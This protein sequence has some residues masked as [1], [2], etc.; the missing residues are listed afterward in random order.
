MAAHAAPLSDDLYGR[1]ALPGRDAPRRV[2]RGK[3]AP[4]R[5]LAHAKGPAAHTTLLA[6][7]PPPAA[8]A[9]PAAPPVDAL[10]RRTPPG[11]LSMAW[12]EDVILGAKP[13]LAAQQAPLHGASAPDDLGFDLPPSDQQLQRAQASAPTPAAGSPDRP[14]TAGEYN[15]VPE[16]A[17]GAGVGGGIRMYN[18]G[19]RVHTRSKAMM[20]RQGRTR[21]RQE[22]CPYTGRIVDYYEDK[23]P[24]A[25]YTRGNVSKEALAH[26]NP[27]LVAAQGYDH[28]RAKKKRR[29][30]LADAPQ[31][32]GH[33]VVP[34][35]VRNEGRV[36]G[37]MEERINR[38][39]RH[40]QNG[41]RPTWMRDTQRPT[42]YVGY[43]NMLRVLPFV[44]PT[45]REGQQNRFDYQHDVTPN[46]NVKAEIDLLRQHM[47][48]NKRRPQVEHAPGLQGHA[49]A[50]EGAQPDFGDRTDRTPTQR[51]HYER[52][53]LLPAG[54]LVGEGSGPVHGERAAPVRSKGLQQRDVAGFAN[55]GPSLAGATGGQAV[56]WTQSVVDFYAQRADNRGRKLQGQQGAIHTG[57]GVRTGEAQGYQA[58][59][60]ADDQTGTRREGQH[61]A[62]HTGHGVR[63][64]AAQGYQAG[65]HAYDQRGTQ[66]E[67][68]HGA[69]HTGHGVRTGA[70]QGYQAGTH[71]Y[72][73]LG[74]Q[75][76]GQQG[77][78]HTGHGVRT[79]AGQGYQAGTHTY[80]QL[81]TQREGQH[82]A[83]HTGHG[84]R[85]G[86]AQG[87]QAGTHTYDQLGTQRE[88]Q[89]GPVLTGHGARTG[90]PQGY[91]AGTHTYDQL[92]TQREGQHGAVAAGMG[93]VSP[94]GAGHGP[95][96]SQNHQ[97]VAPRF[98]GVEVT[99]YLSQPQAEGAR[100][101]TAN[102]AQ[103]DHQ[104][105]Q[106]TSWSAIGGQLAR[107]PATAQQPASA[108]A[109]QA[110]SVAGQPHRE[111]MD[112]SDRMPGPAGAPDVGRMVH[113]EVQLRNGQRAGYGNVGVRNHGGAQ[114]GAVDGES[115]LFPQQ[116][117]LPPDRSYRSNLRNLGQYTS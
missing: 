19:S 79:G 73:Q 68:Q 106:N 111:G 11:V 75:R 93:M 90:A 66:R 49:V 44:E 103:H 5:K 53:H 96:I 17:Q 42:G 1:S 69:V 16:R 71:A 20:E 4:P 92:G 64:G 81:G 57:H 54:D 58:G 15:G 82:G 22:T 94:Q 43:H 41:E 21:V 115:Q 72:D 95:A 99:S 109:N 107:G 3:A 7:L 80:D 38:D 51:S 28:T 116:H 74:T 33:G 6:A 112:V 47:R 30:V 59:M 105:R 31:P 10:T 29:D 102:Q 76:E 98:E 46:P 114:H 104:P 67:G 60:Y 63:T 52:D 89:H 14:W 100:G 36:R 61:G 12:T 83:V 65:T 39:L 26:V 86:A 27:R 101:A 37:E 13:G 91:Q 55:G 117:N 34:D 108:M 77:P 78:V 2:L 9:E 25:N 48:T 110:V 24:E 23:P 50:P 18:Q 113:G 97:H 62:V 70:A 8:A 87:Y 88:G 85:T 45:L 32:D 56:G 84:V 40:N 35:S